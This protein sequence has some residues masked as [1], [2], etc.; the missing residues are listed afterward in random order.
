MKNARRP[1]GN[2][3]AGG[4]GSSQPELFPTLAAP[5]A[6]VNVS[7]FPPN[8]RR[9]LVR[10]RKDRVLYPLFREVALWL[11]HKRSDRIS[12]DAIEHEMKSRYR[13]EGLTFDHYAR[14][15][16]GHL[17][18]FEYPALA[19]RIASRPGALKDIPPEQLRGL[20]EEINGLD[21]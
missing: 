12:A 20:L 2:G 5:S 13:G 11:T 6:S 7:E 3:K 21:A 19:H 8:Y 10:A 9:A 14:T 15:L 17:F 18:R 4:K 16:M 1:G